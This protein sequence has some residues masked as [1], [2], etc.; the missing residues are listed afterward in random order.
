M[1]D[2]KPTYIDGVG[3]RYETEHRH[4]RRHRTHNYNAIGTYLIT[5]TVEDRNPVFGYVD[6][7]LS[8]TKGNANYAHLVPTALATRI[9]NQELQKIHHF[10]PMVKIWKAVLM[11]DH[12]HMI[13]RVGAP[14]PEGKHLGHVIRGFKAGCTKA[15]SELTPP[16][17]SSVSTDDKKPNLFS[18]GYNDRILMKDG[19]LDSWMAYLDENPLRLLIRQRRPDIMSRAICLT[20]N[21]KRYSAYGN[22]MLIKVPEKLQVM[23]HRKATIAMLTQEEQ[24]RY[25]YANHTDMNMKTSV[26]YETTSAFESERAALTEA[27]SMGTVLVTPGI[28]KG[29]QIIKHDCLTQALP[30][31]HLQKE[32]ITALWKPE[33]ERFY[34]C[35]SGKLLILAPWAEDMDGE[36]DYEMFHNLNGLAASICEMRM[37]NARCS[38]AGMRKQA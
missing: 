8:A 4:T 29:E 32:P 24:Q 12:I 6:G 27:A 31:I 17:V 38:Y 16:P 11:P 34:A 13:V 33:R 26:P 21:G 37:V 1:T 9:L 19:Q 35:A 30:L 5:L 25:G 23:C 10:Y 7:D 15:W 20:I 14:L 36:S 18:E 3:W 2:K 28:S 22:F